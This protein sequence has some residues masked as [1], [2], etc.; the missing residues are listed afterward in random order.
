MK[1]EIGEINVREK[2]RVSLKKFDFITDLS[3][4]E[5]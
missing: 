5:F 4:L 1:T 3:C 2:N